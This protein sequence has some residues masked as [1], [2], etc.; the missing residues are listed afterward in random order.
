MKT[1]I[2]FKLNFIYRRK[3]AN[4]HVNVLTILEIFQLEIIRFLNNHSPVWI[5]KLMMQ[6]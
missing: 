1:G 6:N 3:R 4:M 5:I 2:K